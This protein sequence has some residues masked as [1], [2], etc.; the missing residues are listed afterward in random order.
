MDLVLVVT[1]VV[2]AGVVGLAVLLMATYPHIARFRLARTALLAR[3]RSGTAA[4][5]ALRHRS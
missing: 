2:A 1:V 5:E 4:L 3:V